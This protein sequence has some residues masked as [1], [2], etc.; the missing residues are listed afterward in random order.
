MIRAT[1]LPLILMTCILVSI[2]YYSKKL[3]YIKDLVFDICLNL[4]ISN[5]LS[6]S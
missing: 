3:V 6:T 2:I 4:K 5:N 1:I